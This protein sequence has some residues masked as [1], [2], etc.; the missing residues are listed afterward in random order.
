MRTLHLASLFTVLVGLGCGDPG[1]GGERGHVGDRPADAPDGT[2][3]PGPEGPSPVGPDGQPIGSPEPGATGPD[4]VP[5]NPDQPEVPVDDMGN[6]IPQPEQPGQ[7]IEVPDLPEEAAPVTS[8]DEFADSRVRRLTN[9]ELANT[10]AD[11][12]GVTV[13]GAQLPPDSRQND[14]TRNVAQAVDPVLGGHLQ[15]VAG[16]VAS[17]VVGAGLDG[18]VPCAAAGDRA[19]A[20]TFLEDYGS[21]VYRRPLE[22]SEVEALLALYDLGAEGQQ[23]AFASGMEVVLQA[24]LQSASFLYVSEM[25]VP[26]A[27]P[28]SLVLL[29]AWELAASLSYLLTAHPPDP[30]LI[31]AASDGSILEPT[32]REAHARRLLTSPAA[33][34]QIQRFVKQW[35]RLDSVS[36]VDK[37]DDRFANLRGPVEEEADRLISAIAFNG[38]GRLSTM[39]TAGYTFVG[40]ELA[41]FYGV[42]PDGSGRADLAGTG[43]IGLL[44]T[45]SFLA[46]NSHNDESGPIV[47]GVTVLRKLLCYDLPSPSE[48]SD[49]E[50]QNV[51]PPPRDETL[52]TRERFAEHSNN[53]ACTSCHDLIDPI[54]FTFENFDAIGGVRTMDGGKPVDT[55]GA[56]RVGLASDGDVR[57]SVELIRKIAAE[58]RTAECFARHVYRSGMAAAAPAAERTFI[59]SLGEPTA[60]SDDV[61]ALLTALSG[62]NSFLLR[63]TPTSDQQL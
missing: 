10:I 36:T 2:P 45:S 42:S 21:R 48:S 46:A 31:A 24:M 49:P 16:E 57:D 9:A 30:E 58:P 59:R 41:N 17:T 55:S 33:E 54:G 22:T 52:T 4:G 6:P 3:E 26:D 43:R 29:D 19:C 51:M 39:L 62:S 63:R 25:G 61:K 15:R 28:G 37:A 13:D 1:A 20:Q 32:V 27:A 60:I 8:T 44:H 5:V 56:L 40:P 14:F 34:L 7:V 11:L 47:R 18:Y 38:D 50:V 12:F 35:L 23:D 53:P